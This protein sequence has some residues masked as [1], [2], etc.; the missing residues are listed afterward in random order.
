MADEVIVGLIT[1]FG[2]VVSQIIIA[3][4]G[5]QRMRAEHQE[6]SKLIVYR[7]EQLESKVSLHSSVIDRVY[8]L[9]QQNELTKE[10]LVVANHRIE[11]LERLTNHT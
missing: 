10:K 6:S 5:R 2:A 4:A 11:D 3:Y 8:K 7:L 9:E 1:A